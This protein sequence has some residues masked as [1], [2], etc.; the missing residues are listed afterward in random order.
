MFRI[1]QRRTFTKREVFTRG[2]RKQNIFANLVRNHDIFVL[3]LFSKY[4]FK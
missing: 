2:I 3:F 4:N 1:F